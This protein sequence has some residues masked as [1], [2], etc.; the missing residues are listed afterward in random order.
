MSISFNENVHVR[1]VQPMISLSNY[2]PEFMWFMQDEYTF[3]QKHAFGVIQMYE[4]G[5]VNQDNEDKYSIRGLEHLTRKVSLKKKSLQERAWK[6]VLDEQD[7]QMF[8]GL[9]DDEAIATMYAT[10][11]EIN[12]SE[13]IRRGQQ[14][15]VEGCLRKHCGSQRNLET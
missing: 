7:Y 5:L 3:I 4:A 1:I 6:A 14:D 13:A 9:H 10:E 11:C 15:E 2:G 12:A 8:H